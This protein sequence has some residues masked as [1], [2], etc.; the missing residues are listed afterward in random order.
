MVLGV[1]NSLKND[2]LFSP[3]RSANRDALA[4]RDG[5][6][7]SLQATE[8]RLRKDVAFSPILACL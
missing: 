6:S 3:A 4:S 7:R 2:G 5:G 1:V 8:F